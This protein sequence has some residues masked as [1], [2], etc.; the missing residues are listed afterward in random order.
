[1]HQTRRDNEPASG[2]ILIILAVGLV[3]LITNALIPSIVGTYVDAYSLS[4]TAA[5]WTA[6]LYMVTASVGAIT[7]TALMLRFPARWLAALSLVLLA[8]ANLGSI[9]VREPTLI[10]AV[11]AIAGAGEGAGY[12]LMSAAVTRQANP[13]RTFAIFDVALLALCAAI[14]SLVPTVRET[15]GP[16]YIFLLCA[17]GPIIV[18]PFVGRFPDLTQPVRLDDTPQTDDPSPAPSL[19]IFAIAAMLLIYVGYGATFAYL[20][21]IG[22][23]LGTTPDAVARILSIGYAVGGVGAL[24]ALLTHASPFRFARMLIAF[25]VSIAAIVFAMEPVTHAYAIGVI[26]FFFAWFY[27]LPNLSGLMSAADPRGRI[28]AATTGAQGLGI[29]SG[30]ALVGTWLSFSGRDLTDG[31]R[32]ISLGGYGLGAALLVAIVMR[33]H[34]AAE[35]GKLTVLAR[36]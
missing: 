22:V 26:T 25:A 35:K 10:L 36:A 33:V 20:D 7:V 2:T 29:A 15:L 32:F 28:A 8:I 4:L 27:F 3:V 31:A 5:G 30:P 24:A 16:A 13:V 18:L 12:A 21:R 34:R 6:T 17:I 19:F 9:W 1:M 11:R 23:A 14:Q